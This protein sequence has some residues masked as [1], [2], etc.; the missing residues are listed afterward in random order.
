MCWSE[1]LVT[2]VKLARASNWN[3]HWAMGVVDWSKGGTVPIV[4]GNIYFMSN[5][6]RKVWISFLAMKVQLATNC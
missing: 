1:S 6:Q 2:F 3:S 4:V 5:F